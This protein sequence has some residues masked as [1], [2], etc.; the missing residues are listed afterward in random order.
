M[1]SKSDILSKCD[2]FSELRPLRSII[3]PREFSEVELEAIDFVIESFVSLKES[4]SAIA[5]TAVTKLE[6]WL[7]STKDTGSPT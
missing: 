7:A 3:S 1:I 6:L 2:T 4:I 5:D